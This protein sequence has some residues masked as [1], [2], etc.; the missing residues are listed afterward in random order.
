M[1]I[2]IGIAILIVA[3]GNRSQST[4]S[5][6]EPAGAELAVQS[7]WDDEPVEHLEPAPKTER[8]SR[9]YSWEQQHAKT[10]AKGGLVW[11][12]TP[13]VFEAGDSVRYIDFAEGRDSNDGKTK[14][15]AW[16]HH[17]WDSAAAGQAASCSGVHTYVFKRGTHYRGTL[18]ARESGQPGNPIRLT[19]DPSWGEGR[20]RHLRFCEESRVA[21]RR[22]QSIVISRI[23]SKVWYTDLDFAPRNVWL[24]SGEEITRIP[25]ARMPNWK[26]SD[27]EDVKKEWWFWDNPGHPYFHLTMK[28]DDGRRELAMGRDTKHITGP[29]D[30]YMGAIIWAEFGWVDGTPYPSYVQ[31][32]DAAK[33]ALGFEGYLGSPKSRVICRYHRYYLEDK[34]HYLDDHEGEFWFEKKRQRRTASYHPARRARPER[35]RH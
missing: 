26:V 2:A 20:G 16:K 8:T 18:S 25:L 32:F 4:E 31:G 27:P 24:V 19:S 12:P 15:T 7:Q 10:D 22:V 6:V 29:K 9:E 17:P 35:G 21:G 14:N 34:P 3:V 33:N 23:R 30:L 1:A 28:S 5:A 13:F 11:T